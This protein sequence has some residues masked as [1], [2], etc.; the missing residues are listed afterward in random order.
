MAEAGGWA[1]M[2]GC[3]NA[4]GSRWTGAEG[5]GADVGVLADVVWLGA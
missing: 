2:A 5:G 1:G 4:G 3:A